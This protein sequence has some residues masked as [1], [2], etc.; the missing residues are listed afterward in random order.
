MF[1]EPAGNSLDLGLTRP[2]K[3]K[4]RRVLGRVLGF[5]SRRLRMDSLVTRFLR[6]LSFRATKQQLGVVLQLTTG[7]LALAELREEIET[8]CAA[9]ECDPGV[10]EGLEAAVEAVESELENALEQSL[11]LMDVDG[12]GTVTLA[13]AL[14]FLHKKRILL[15]TI[16]GM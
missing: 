9:G 1:I 12:D 11:S 5:F 3:P 6:W 2:S 7:A 14:T 4:K 16:W 8:A 15:P 13:E 10:R